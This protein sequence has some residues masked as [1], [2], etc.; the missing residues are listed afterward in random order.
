MSQALYTSKTGID[1]GQT[2]I[3]VISNNVANINTTA[4]KTANVTFS[5]LFSKTLS[6]GSA[7]TNDG[8]GTNPRQIGL[9]TQVSSISRNFEAGTF[10][11]TGLTSDVMIQG[12][13]YFVV[14]DSAGNQYLTRDGHFSLDSDGNMVNSSGYKVIGTTA[15]Y[16]N[17]STDHTIQVPS[18]LS[19]DVYGT[20]RGEI[21]DKTI[22]DFNSVAISSGTFI[23]NIGGTTQTKSAAHFTAA[24]N[25][26]TYDDGAGTVVNYTLLDNANLSAADSESI[27]SIWGSQIDMTEKYYKGDDG[28]FIKGDIPQTGDVLVKNEQAT[29]SYT[30]SDGDLNSTLQDLVTSINAELSQQTIAMG[31]AAGNTVQFSIVDGGLQ[32]TNTTGLSLKSADKGQT[33]NFLEQTD[34]DDALEDAVA[35]QDAFLSTTLNKSVDIGTGGSFVTSPRRTGWSVSES[36]VVSATY[37]D[38]TTVT[39][40][41]DE[42]GKILWKIITKDNTTITGSGGANSDVDMTAANL[43]PENM[44]ME[45]AAVINDAGLISQAGNLWTIGPNA[46]E[47]YYG[48][49]GSHGFSALKTGG[50]E[51]SNVDMATELSNMIMAQRAIQAN[52]RVFSTASAVLETIT[53][54][55]Q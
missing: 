18:K 16:T 8:G 13:G 27:R 3:N 19:I 41:S 2:Y 49:S 4:Y 54:L 24:G 42:N 50:L 15:S 17:K 34:I 52:S 35:G 23:F 39:V 5:T 38:G 45:M 26:Y 48:M 14:Q 40:G 43:V 22:G 11:Q 29:L 47:A 9:G 7:A 12:G 10:L 36:G 55:G 30:L 20:P 21:A 44:I 32:L 46:G 33:S 53:Y 1:A 25:D 28:T 51:G 31:L 6:T 37:D